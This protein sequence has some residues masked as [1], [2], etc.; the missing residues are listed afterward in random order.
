MT[1]GAGD[2]F[3]LDLGFDGSNPFEPPGYGKNKL[4]WQWLNVLGEWGNAP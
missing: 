4:G 1:V 3:A 2:F